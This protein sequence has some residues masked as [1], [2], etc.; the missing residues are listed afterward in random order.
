MEKACPI[1]ALSE[2]G[3]PF[4]MP[5]RLWADT[6]VSLHLWLVGMAAGLQGSRTRN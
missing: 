2:A 4:R 3:E 5:L 6:L 1:R